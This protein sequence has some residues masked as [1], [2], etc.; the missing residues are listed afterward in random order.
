MLAL[1]ER[2]HARAAGDI[3]YNLWEAKKGAH[4][5]AAKAFL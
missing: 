2:H 3:S 5:E 4:F 1:G